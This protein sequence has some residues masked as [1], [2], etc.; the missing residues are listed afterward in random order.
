MGLRRAIAL[1]LTGLMVF[2]SVPA[3]TLQVYAEEQTEIIEEDDDISAEESSDVV[4]TDAAGSESEEVISESDIVTEESTAEP[5]ETVSEE[6]TGTETGD[7][8]SD[9]AESEEE[10]AAV[11]EEENAAPDMLAKTPLFTDGEEFVNDGIRYRV[12]SA[13]DKTLEILGFGDKEKAIYEV[14][15]GNRALKIYNYIYVDKNDKTK[16]VDQYIY[17]EDDVPWDNPN[18]V[19]CYVETVVANA[20]K[21]EDGFESLDDTIYELG[22]QAFNSCLDLTEGYVAARMGTGVFKNCE[23]LVSVG[24]QGSAKIIPES[25]FEGCSSLE[26][27]YKLSEGLTA[28]ESKAFADC[29]SLKRIRIPASVTSI[30]EDAFDGCPS[31]LIIYAAD[32]TYAAEYAEAHGYSPQSETYYLDTTEINISKSNQT[33]TINIKSSSGMAYAGIFNYRITGECANM[34]AIGSRKNVSSEGT[35]PNRNGRIIIYSL[36][37]RNNTG[38]GTANVEIELNDGTRLDFKVNIVENNPVKKLKFWGKDSSG[39]YTVQL[40]NSQKYY[41]TVG[42]KMD[43]KYTVE[44]AAGYSDTIEWRLQDKAIG[45]PHGVKMEVDETDK[46][47]VHITAIANS[48]SVDIVQP[49][50][51]GS[52]KFGTFRFNVSPEVELSAI[53]GETISVPA[54]ATARIGLNIDPKETLDY[55]SLYAYLGGNVMITKKEYDEDMHEEVDMFAGY[56][57]SRYVKIANG[58]EEYEEGYGGTKYPDGYFYYDKD[59]QYIDVKGLKVGE[60]VVNIHLRDKSITV[61]VKV[62]AP[63]SI[64]S[65]AMTDKDGKT[66]SASDTITLQEADTESIKLNAVIAPE[67][68][69]DDKVV[70]WT[71]S[72]T[73]VATVDA[74]GNVSVAGPGYA[75]IKASIPSSNG[76]TYTAS[77]NVKVIPNMTGVS[78]TLDPTELSMR[79]GETKRLGVSIKK[80]D[81]ELSSETRKLFDISVTKADNSG[82]V[83]LTDKVAASSYIDVKGLRD[84]N[85]TVKIKVNIP[86]GSAETAV[87]KSADVTVTARNLNLIDTG[88]HVYAAL[89]PIYGQKL[90]NLPAVPVKE[91]TEEEK[92]AGFIYLP[93]GWYTEPDGNGT[94]VTSNTVF[95]D[96]LL[97]DEWSLYAAYKKVNTADSEALAFTVRPI[98]DMVYTGS[99]IT[100]EVQVYYG[101]QLLTQGKDYTV[102]YENNT[103]AAGVKLDDE[104]ENPKAPKAVITG[105]GNYSDKVIVPFNILPKSIADE[106]VTDNAVTLVK[107][108]TYKKGTAVE[109][110]LTPALKYGKVTLSGKND[111]DYKLEY[112]SGDE[113]DTDGNVIKRAYAD[114]GIWNIKITGNGN[115]TGERIVSMRLVE[116]AKLIGKLKVN[117]TQKSFD[118]TGE[119]IEAPVTVKD[120]SKTTLVLNEDYILSYEDNVAP[121]TASVTVTM[122]GNRYAGSKT[123]TYT[124]KGRPIKKAKVENLINLEYTSKEVTHP[125]LKLSYKVG[126]EWEPMTADDYDVIY[127][128]NENAGKATVVFAGKGIYEGTLKK[129]FK[130]LPYAIDA[131]REKGSRFEVVPGDASICYTKGGTLYNYFVKFNCGEEPNVTS[132]WFELFEG[133]DYKVSYKNNK[134]VAK[135]TDGKKAPTMTIQGKGNFKGKIDVTY[136]IA[137][138]YLSEYSVE[139]YAANVV[140]KNKKGNWKSAPTVIDISSGQKL[141]AGTDYKAKFINMTTGEELKATDTVDAGTEVKIEL[142]AVIPKTG[143][144]NY[145]DADTNAS[146]T[147]TVTEY[148]K[149]IGKTGYFKIRDKAY[150][151]RD[152]MLTADDFEQMEWRPTKSSAPTVLTMATENPDGSY[153]GDFIIVSYSKNHYKGTATVVLKGVNEYSGTKTVKFRITAKKMS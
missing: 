39:N 7:E 30:A 64:T 105:K 32:G 132:E 59:T 56:T 35:S 130:I 117:L 24:M 83:S 109:Q 8:V 38:T 144:P 49:L 147:Y 119:A 115:Y 95:E 146:Y 28:I 127:F 128:D 70:T 103:N 11:S 79:S 6:E 123:L 143:E 118:Y 133:E 41:L 75:V 84:G 108:V 45:V 36:L 43:I 48:S 93:L 135:S 15:P 137:P 19:E 90:A 116:G 136:D 52:G 87:S 9:A 139:V 73:K 46:S 102:R 145:R 107:A 122:I 16:S 121:G 60:D 17:D 106:D 99:K 112:I 67:N 20:F 152:I 34:I 47:I 148:D 37:G 114:A 101:D 55:N 2:T 12:I 72:D 33:R 85:T 91:P 51:S 50:V 71:S 80:N 129:T 66:V 53:D 134:A 62:T 74:D 58:E 63:N 94:L 42:Q 153:T 10:T 149:N 23:K 54:G 14:E 82:V 69:T 89:M 113:K 150:T 77:V 1:L 13:E 124:I 88:N 76:K 40:K 22:D 31:D 104:T 68:T 142:S 151:G 120:G 29:T 26:N 81:K 78:V 61:K 100:P 57:P 21:N 3:N 138:N 92:K 27:V 141:K 65:L 111:K 5:S 96:G 18:A 140:Y 97:S 98:A 44:P 131:E 126:S 25:S 125:N 86:G 4:V 110:R